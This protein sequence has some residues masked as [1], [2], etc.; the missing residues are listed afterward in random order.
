MNVSRTRLIGLGLVIFAATFCL[1]SPTRQ[2]EFLRGDDWENLHHAIRWNGLSWGAVK[3]AF[4][5]AAPYYQPLP[6][7][8]HTLDYQIWRK[9]AAGHHLTSVVLHAVNAVLVFGLVWTLLGAT[10]LTMGERLAM[11]CG[12]SVAFAI[13]PLQVETVAWISGRTHL[14]C[15]TFSIASVWAYVAGARRWMVWALYAAA[16]VSQP[17]AVSLPLTMLVLDYFP[18]RRDKEAGWRRLLLEKIPLLGLGILMVA[19]TMITG[20]RFAG[21]MVPMKAFPVTQRVLLMFENL[22]FYPAKLFW[23][24]HLSPFY[25]MPAG[26]SL[27][28]WPV[29]IAV[30]SVGIIALVAVWRWRRTPAL[31]VGCVV[32][33]MMIL[34]VSG[35]MQG[36]SQA[37]APRYAYL[38]ILPLLLLAGGAAVW[39]WRRSA[40]VARAALIGLLLVAV[41]GCKWLTHKT[42]LVWRNDE[43]LWRS[44]LAEFPDWEL[45][46][47]LMAMSLM[48]QGRGR[49]AL[50]C[51]ERYV[52]IAPGQRDAHNT[53]GLVMTQLG[54]FDAAVKQYER[55]LQID[56]ENAEAHFNLATAF[57]RLGKTENEDRE[58]EA[59]LRL[60]PDYLEAHVNFGSALLRQGRVTE[61]LGHLQEGLR[62][63]PDY[64][65]TY[66]YLGNALLLQ[67]RVPEAIARYEEALRIDPEY[68][69]AQWGLG[70]ALAMENRPSEAI[71][72][73]EEALRL[74]PEYAEA[75]YN[76]GR[77]LAGLGRMPEAMAQW[78]QV[79]RIHPDDVQAHYSLGTAL[80]QQGKMPEAIKEYNR[81]L[82]LQPGFTAARDA[83]ARLQGGH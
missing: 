19:V 13:H 74:D 54:G 2:G 83:L 6:R 9:H 62:I 51:A 10:S 77:V 68:A 27:G 55:V 48:D 40:T 8:S 78:E 60:R 53:L 37:M 44:V 72:H 79:L 15:A 4:T 42:I 45:P 59:A 64:V 61:A 34:P 71:Q 20:W 22:A 66:Y 11:A 26:L 38:A 1:Y 7:L 80:E 67:Q 65:G 81:V 50:D 18:L 47:K 16:V 57:A 56:P 3:W 58:Y 43:T 70:N 41:C 25:P 76:L 63:N 31:A 28:Q 69:P 30:L 21:P 49:E 29:L 14:L 33:V 12:V 32:Y 75:H 23:P 39:L 52:K 36:G 24:A 46:N 17:I 82:Q 5:T 35:P 73:Y